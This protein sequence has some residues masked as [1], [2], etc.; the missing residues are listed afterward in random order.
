M[1]RKNDQQLRALRQSNKT[2]DQKLNSKA[3]TEIVHKM[4]KKVIIIT[5][6]RRK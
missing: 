6:S 5:S 4:L 1:Q 2:D 3:I